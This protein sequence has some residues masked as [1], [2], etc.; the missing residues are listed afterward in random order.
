MPPKADAKKLKLQ[1]T[2]KFYISAIEREKSSASDA[3]QVENWSI[4]DAKARLDLVEKS[5]AKYEQ[6]CIDLCTDASLDQDEALAMQKENDSMQKVILEITAIYHARIKH[7]ESE[8]VQANAQSEVQPQTVAPI[9]EPFSCTVFSAD[10]G[11]WFSFKN[12]FEASAAK[13]PRMSSEEKFDELNQR[14]YGE[15]KMIVTRLSGNDFAK[16]MENLNNVFGSVYKQLQ[17]LLNQ[18]LEIPA[19]QS[20]SRNTINALVNKANKCEAGLKQVNRLDE[21]DAILTLLIVSKLDGETKR[22]WDRQRLVLANSWCQASGEG[23]TVRKLADYM[24][25]WEQLK[26]FLES[27]VLIYEFDP[28]EGASCSTYRPNKNANQATVSSTQAMAVAKR[29][30]PIF[31]QCVL[32]TGIHPKYKCEAFIGMS[33][34]DRWE[35]VRKEKLCQ[36]CLRPQHQGKCIAPGCNQACTYCSPAAVFHNSLLCSARDTQVRGQSSNQVNANQ[37]NASRANAN[38]ANEENWDNQ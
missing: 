34:I 32:C 30:A 26:K 9:E 22:A 37:A 13:K 24:P 4:S 27:E 31:L 5:Y 29:S 6:A 23:Q 7:L 12:E 33:L 8:A 2:C 20:P 17:H 14:C 28:N 16:A 11:Q 1:K 38:R 15:A 19:I 3:S 25:P 35:H 10:I 18:L 36:Q 21:F